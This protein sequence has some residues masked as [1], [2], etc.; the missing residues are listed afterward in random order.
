MDELLDIGQFCGLL[1]NMTKEELLA[2]LL[3]TIQRVDPE[4]YPTLMDAFKQNLEAIDAIKSQAKQEAY[5]QQIIDSH[6][7]LTDKLDELN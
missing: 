2:T 6:K 3:T 7:R 5:S 1:E 4:L